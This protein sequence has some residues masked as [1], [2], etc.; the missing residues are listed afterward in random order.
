VGTTLDGNSQNVSKRL[1][2]A[3]DKPT[4]DHLRRFECI[5]WKHIPKS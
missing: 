2:S 5:V 1:T 3:E 4:Q